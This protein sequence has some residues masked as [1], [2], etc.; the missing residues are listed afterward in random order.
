MSPSVRRAIVASFAVSG[1]AFEVHAE[2]V[3]ANRVSSFP[4]SIGAGRDAKPVLPTAV[5]GGAEEI[6]PGAGRVRRGRVTS[7][8][9][10]RRFAGGPPHSTTPR[11]VRLSRRRLALP[12]RPRS[13]RTPR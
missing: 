12:P 11:G 2:E 8:E 4:S 6:F 7:A 3:T 1:T 13:P 5:K 9:A 10:L